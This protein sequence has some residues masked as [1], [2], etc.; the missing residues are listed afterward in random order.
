MIGGA[1][2]TFAK[3]NDEFR[4]AIVCNAPFLEDVLKVIYLEE[5]LSEA[6]GKAY[7]SAKQGLVSVI[8]GKK[9]KASV[10]ISVKDEFKGL[11]CKISAFGTFLNK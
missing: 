10:D 11:S 8:S 6:L 7:N 2:L 3:Y 9:E 5:D 4:D 1:T